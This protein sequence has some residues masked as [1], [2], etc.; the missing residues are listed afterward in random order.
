MERRSL[1]AGLAA[2]VFGLLVL[3]AMVSVGC[4]SDETEAS[5]RPPTAR[6]VDPQQRRLFAGG[7]M[8][9][10]FEYELT[11]G[12]S[13]A[14]GSVATAHLEIAEKS[15]A[16]EHGRVVAR[17]EKV[18][19][20]ARATLF[21]DGTDRGGK[22][23]AENE[24][25]AYVV[26][27]DGAGHQAASKPVPVVVYRPIAVQGVVKDGTGR[28]VGGAQ[29]KVAETDISVTTDDDGSF[30]LDSCPMG[31]RT[32]IAS[33]AGA[34][35]GS[36]RVKLNHSSGAVAV[37]LGTTE[38]DDAGEVQLASTGLVTA[39]YGHSDSSVTISGRLFYNDDNGVARPMSGVRVVLQDD[40]TA[41]WDDLYTC[42]SSETGHFSFTYD[43]DD[44]WDSWNE[45]DVR[46]VAYAE[47]QAADVCGVYDGYW[48]LDPYEFVATPTWNDNQSS[49]TGLACYKSGD[50]SVA[51]F[52]YDCARRAHDRW[53]GLTGH[54]RSYVWVDYPAETG[55][56]SGQFEISLAYTCINIKEG[57]TEWDP[58]TTYH[59]YG[60]SVHYALSDIPP[61]C[62][63][64]A[65][66]S[67]G[68][69]TFYEVS[70]GK[71]YTEKDNTYGIDSE[72]GAWSALKEGFA[73]FFAAL[74]MDWDRGAIG[75]VTYE[76][77]VDVGLGTSSDKDD[78][79]IAHSVAKALWDLY[80]GT[81]TPLCCDWEW[82]SASPPAKVPAHSIARP[83]GPLGDT[84]DDMLS[85]SAAAPFGGTLAMLVDVL[86]HDFP[87]D[88]HELYH[89]LVDR[90]PA[91]RLDHTGLQAVFYSQGI[92]KD[93]PVESA[94]QVSDTLIVP[95]PDAGAYRGTVR[96]YVKVDDMNGPRDL[97][98]MGVRL[99]WGTAGTGGDLLVAARVHVHQTAPCPTR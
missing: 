38:G 54:D 31:F 37:V 19:A 21:W 89:A 46:V 6:I 60:H 63:A 97:D 41:F 12:T 52:I 96:V 92:L 36:G 4:R 42:T 59:E 78:A 9:V 86:R 71:W 27:E 45:P 40:A 90:Y 44:V 93:H 26:T 95:A 82:T 10:A 49:R 99:E 55:D 94:P 28:G 84:D 25:L 74:M 39:A 62:N 56:A 64:Y 87:A 66:Y 18:P 14:P 73:E 20:Q 53:Q 33:K 80:D 24:Y 81:E 5:S 85:N 88:V 48:S 32:F 2:L 75:G 47:D 34:G 1:G 22:I 16:E 29:V 7:G 79:R 58:A 43:Y 23:V 13:G 30:H 8:S 77:N 50:D 51:W 35:S 61:T 69:F 65:A 72:G 15:G 3:G 11:P 76:R 91:S 57:D 17:T 68:G 70:K 98:R 67:H 83:V